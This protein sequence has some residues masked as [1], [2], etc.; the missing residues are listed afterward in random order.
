MTGY[1]DAEEQANVVSGDR[2][3]GGSTTTITTTTTT[4]IEGMEI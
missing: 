4:S 2:N 1:G 3:C